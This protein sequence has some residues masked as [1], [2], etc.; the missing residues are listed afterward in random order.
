[1]SLAAKSDGELEDA[2]VDFDPFELNPFCLNPY[3][4]GLS[5][6]ALA[7][8]FSS[9][10]ISVVCSGNDCNFLSFISIRTIRIVQS[11]CSIS[12]SWKDLERDPVEAV[13]GHNMKI[14]SMDKELK[15]ENEIHWN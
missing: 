11:S 6:E 14:D 13:E 15:I 3:K 2:C 9:F 1:M 4:V 7:I 10:L 8:G 5:E 12:A